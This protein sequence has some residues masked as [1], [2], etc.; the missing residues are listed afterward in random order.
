MA[1]E[2]LG[3]RSNLPRKY[4]LVKPSPSYSSSE[5]N[6]KVGIRRRERKSSIRRRM[7]SIKFGVA[8]RIVKKAMSTGKKQEKTKEG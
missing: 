7:S 1:A 4:P 2:D 6:G 5:E 8:H 3:F